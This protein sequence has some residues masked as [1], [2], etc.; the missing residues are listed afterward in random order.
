MGDTVALKLFGHQWARLQKIGE[1]IGFKAIFAALGLC[2]AA[3][4]ALGVGSAAYFS[5][6][7][8]FWLTMTPDISGKVDVNNGGPYMNFPPV[9]IGDGDNYGNET[10]RDFDGSYYGYDFAQCYSV[11]GS[12][13]AT[14]FQGMATFLIFTNNSTSDPGELRIDALNTGFVTT[15]GNAVANSWGGMYDYTQQEL[16]FFHLIS[17]NGSAASYDGA[18]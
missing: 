8:Q 4:Q 18:G 2:F 1:C 11:A 6:Y 7:T 15:S 3:S 12:G 17:T 5:S 13:Y 16:T 10:E 9:A 14:Q